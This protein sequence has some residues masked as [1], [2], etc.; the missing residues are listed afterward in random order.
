MLGCC[1]ERKLQICLLGSR[2]IVGPLLG[3][4]RR[5]WLGE[6]GNILAK[7]AASWPFSTAAGERQSCVFWASSFMTLSLLTWRFWGSCSRNCTGSRSQ[8]LS[9]SMFVPSEALN[10]WLVPLCLFL[11][12]WD[13][14]SVEWDGYCCGH[15]ARH[16][17]IE[18]PFSSCILTIW[19]KLKLAEVFGHLSR[20]W[21]HLERQLL[22]QQG[23]LKIG[24]QS[25]T[26]RIHLG[27]T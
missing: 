5:M 12:T 23:C 19:G 10:T 20:P 27:I 15:V 11:D 17:K 2:N 26:E 22:Q 13:S 24:D 9:V 16:C 25:L 21:R 4:V 1:P 3:R 7:E 8:A 14:A 18:R 6:A